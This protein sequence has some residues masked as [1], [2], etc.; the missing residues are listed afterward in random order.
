MP[1]E[2][3]GWQRPD[4]GAV[5]GRQIEAKPEVGGSVNHIALSKKASL[6]SAL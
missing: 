5:V 4:T 1:D 3:F 6:S 2:R